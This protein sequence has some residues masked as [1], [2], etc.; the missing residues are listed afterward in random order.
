MNPVGFLVNNL[1]A[2]G[3]PRKGGQ[4]NIQLLPRPP[5]D[6]TRT[7]VVLVRHPSGRFFRVGVPPPRT[8]IGPIQSHPNWWK[9]APKEEEE[10][11]VVEVM[12]EEFIQGWQVHL[13]MHSCVCLLLSLRE[14]LYT[15]WHI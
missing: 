3:D 5:I 7:M 14:I 8:V 12:V 9:S 4:G 10:E 11:E 2:L 1:S 15:A 6:Q 13:C